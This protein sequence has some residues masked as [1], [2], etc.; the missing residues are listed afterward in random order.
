[1]LAAQYNY[2]EIIRLFLSRGHVISKP[3]N[4]NCSCSDC[5]ELYETGPLRLAQA[6][7]NTYR[8]LASPAYIILSSKDPILTTFQLKE[9]LRY[10]VS[11][12]SEFMHDYKVL[13][14]QCLQFSCELMDLCRSTKE[15]EAI[16]GDT[17]ADGRDPLARFKLAM[18]LQ[19]K[20]FVAHPH[21]QEYLST[22]FYGRFNHMKSL[23][24]WKKIAVIIV[25]TPFLPLLFLLY[26][27][28][29]NSYVG[30]AL[31]TPAVKLATRTVSYICFL[32]L[33][34]LAT[35]RLDFYT[36]ERDA[37]GTLKKDARFRHDFRPAQDALVTN[38]QWCLVFWILGS[39]WTECKQV[40]FSGFKD[41]F[42]DFYN[43][44]DTFMMAFY[45]AS[46]ALRFVAQ[47]KIMETQYFFDAEL[48]LARQLLFSNSSDSVEQYV[49][50]RQQ[51]FGSR[52]PQAYFLRGDRFWWDPYDPEIVSDCL[53]AV[54]NVL[55]F[56]RLTYIMPVAEFLGPL[57]ISLGRMFG[58][59]VRFTILFVLIMSAFVL[60]LC[61]L[62]WY[63]GMY[64]I[65]HGDSTVSNEAFRGLS[66]TFATLFWALFGLVDKGDTAIAAGEK[67]IF[68]VPGSPR[69]VEG[70]GTVLFAAYHAAMIIIIL[71]MLIALMSHSFE[72]VQADTDQEWKF[73]RARLWL[74]SIE[75]GYTLPA[76]FN[77]I[78]S[79]KSFLY[80][81]TKLGKTYHR[82]KRHSEKEMANRQPS[83]EYKTTIRHI[84]KR[85][86]FKLE[87]ER[88]NVDISE[89]KAVQE[90]PKSPVTPQGSVL[91]T[92]SQSMVIPEA[93]Q[94][95]REKISSRL[96]EQGA[97]LTE[98]DKSP[99][100]APRSGVPSS[101]SLP[102]FPINSATPASVPVRSGQAKVISNTRHHPDG[103]NVETQ[104]VA[105]VNPPRS[106]SLN[107]AGGGRN[108]ARSSSDVIKG[109][110]KP[111][112]PQTLRRGSLKGLLTQ[113]DS[114][115]S[116]SLRSSEQ[117]LDRL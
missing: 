57:Q 44:I 19:E 91:P 22:I 23:A 53:F 79:P 7:L 90:N 82:C 40:Y 21:T 34:A 17:D 4:L 80:V 32:L 42:W 13:I 114:Q 47:M 85:Y 84:A 67:Q 72:D 18:H 105:W 68:Q 89:V 3:H 73:A 111:P 1:M 52:I 10:I 88:H 38:I 62:Y 92:P 86:L 113:V 60:G 14:G 16:L 39:F 69:L 95:L 83:R 117:D 94:A 33:I 2:H 12:K 100:P 24:S 75:H 64:V 41:Y 108:H 61:N 97:E 54:A 48:K 78:P 56:S 77:I 26:L 51:L 9:E 50:F 59:I 55:S 5:L 106:L 81:F 102:A 30:M 104:E 49:Q 25:I 27:V 107:T 103:T 11:R 29:P 6:R 37:S 71:N 35:F 70:V 63:Y 31:K 99:K 87:Q 74:V 96:L 116:D 115:S 110:L 15:V 46:Y 36:T 43:V 112:T 20:K 65:Q 109:L 98:D 28:A 45:A 66:Q 93:L 58:D 76:P 8:A 101:V